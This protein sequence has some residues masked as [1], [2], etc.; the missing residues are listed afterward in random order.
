MV[1]SLKKTFC[2]EIFNGYLTQ[3][4]ACVL[5]KQHIYLYLIFINLIY[6][7]KDTTY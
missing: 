7:L 4:A 1:I 5:K 2:Y 6:K 3:N